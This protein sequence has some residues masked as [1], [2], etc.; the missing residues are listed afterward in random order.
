M[1][2][3]TGYYNGG[4]NVWAAV[5]LE[6]GQYRQLGQVGLSDNLLEQRRIHVSNLAF[7]LVF[8]AA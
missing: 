7:G 3:I 1:V 6:I 4:C 2:S 5:A 8:N